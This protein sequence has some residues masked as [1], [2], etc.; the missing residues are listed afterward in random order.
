MSRLEIGSANA[1]GSLGMAALDGYAAA[2][3]VPTVRDLPH[4]QHPE[5][6]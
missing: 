1:R 2:I 5:R 4:P 6:R 3:E